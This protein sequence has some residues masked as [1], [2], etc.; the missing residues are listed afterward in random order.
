MGGRPKVCFC[1]NLCFVS[2]P[3]CLPFLFA[4]EVSMAQLQHFFLA[5]HRQSFD[6]TKVG[7]F[8]TAQNLGVLCIT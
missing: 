7:N 4:V 6:A 1:F 2:F 5:C 3:D 8:G